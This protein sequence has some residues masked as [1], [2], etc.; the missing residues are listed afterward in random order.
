MGNPTWMYRLKDGAVEAK[1]FD[2][3][4]L[5]KGWVDAPP[6]VEAF[7]LETADKNALEAY[8]KEK[9]GVDLDKRKG[10]DKLR[11]Q[12]RELDGHGE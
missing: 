2:S 9:H 11:E 8:A 7:D 5:P 4:D 1:I 10:I 6:K 12:V 3:D